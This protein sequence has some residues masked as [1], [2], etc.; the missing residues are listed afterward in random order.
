MANPWMQHLNRY[1]ISHTN[2]SYKECMIE[3]KKTYKP[4]NKKTVGKGSIAMKLQDPREDMM[5]KYMGVKLKNENDEIIKRKLAK[6]S[7]KQVK[8]QNGDGLIDDGVEF[9]K[10]GIK[11]GTEVYNEAKTR[12]ETAFK[13]RDKIP[14]KSRAV[15]DKYGGEKITALG[16]GRTPIDALKSGNLITL[17][18]LEK[19]IKDVGH[20]QLF[21]LYCII[22]L[23]SNKKIIIEKNDSINI[24]SVVPYKKTIS[25]NVPIHNNV[26][27]AQS[28]ENTENRM[29]SNHFIKYTASDWNCQDFLKNYLE[30]NGWMKSEYKDF[31]MQNTKQLMNSLPKSFKA[32]IDTATN[33]GSAVDVLMTGGKHKIRHHRNVDTLRSYQ[34]N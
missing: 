15:V 11:K 12:I 25:I 31:I 13:G 29:G 19:K 20:D 34:I 24:S 27:L 9:F 8:L 23:E 14:P 10:K 30:A 22:T 28:L 26:T 18:Y 5:K 16:I 17:G 21:H 4:A 3:A 6:V 33:L 1:Q 32:V 7:M 2:L